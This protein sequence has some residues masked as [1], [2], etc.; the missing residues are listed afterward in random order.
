MT[1]T[2]ATPVPQ[3]LPSTTMTA[4]EVAREYNC[5]D[6]VVRQAIRDGEIPVLDLYGG[7]ADGKNGTGKVSRRVYRMLRS[8]VE[9]W[10]KS[11]RVRLNAAA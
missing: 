5:A 1:K 3:D 4:R 6:S 10:V 9:A 2:P 11:K 7:M 8:D